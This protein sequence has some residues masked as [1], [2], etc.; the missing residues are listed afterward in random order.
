MR[1]NKTI[2]N[3]HTFFK[4]NTLSKVIKIGNAVSK[5][6]ARKYYI[7]F[8]VVSKEGCCFFQHSIF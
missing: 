4:R 2:F 1:E 3:I 6:F 5:F 7:S 8:K